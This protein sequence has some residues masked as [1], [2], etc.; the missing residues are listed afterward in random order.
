MARYIWGTN[1]GGKAMKKACTGAGARLWAR[2]CGAGQDSRPQDL[3]MA[4]A[5]P[6]AGTAT[7]EWAADIGRPERHHQDRDLSR[8]S[9]SVGVRPLRHGARRHRRSNV[10]QSRLP[11][12]PLCR[13]LGRPAALQ[14]SP[15]P[16]RHGRARRLYRKY[17]ATE[18]KGHAFLLR[19]PVEPGGYHGRKKVVLRR[20]SRA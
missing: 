11:A 1:I 9:S 3:D 19:L 14:C 16:R 8:P 7:K 15:T 18:M 17:A 13:H 6:S 12:G 2:R 10:R 20:T 5:R 4:A